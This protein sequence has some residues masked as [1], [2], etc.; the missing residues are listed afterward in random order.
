MYAAIRQYQVDSDSS[1]EVIRQIN[2]HF[3]PLIKEAQGF[4]AYHVVDAE[5]GR[6]ATVSIFE[7]REGMETSNKLAARWMKEH[8]AETILAR[9]GLP[10]FFLKVE[11]ILQ[12]PLSG[13]VPGF[14]GDEGLQEEVRGLQRGE[15]S[16]SLDTRAPQLLSIDQLCEEMG[17]GKSWVYRRIRSGEIPSIRLGKAIKVQRAD[18]EEYLRSRRQRPP[19][20]E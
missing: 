18:L 16:A 6:F 10:S 19:A 11:K 14:V 1:T 3:V 13:V 12:G 20:G 15:A 5:D 4:V 7:D 9:A 17:M 8:L 2:E